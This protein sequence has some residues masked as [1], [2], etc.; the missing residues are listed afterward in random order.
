MCD[1]SGPT[2]ESKGADGKETAAPNGLS[3]AWISLP[4][5]VR[6]IGEK[7]AAKPVTST[8]SMKVP[9]Y[10][11]P[12]RYGFGRQPALFAYA[13]AAV[14][15]GGA[16]VATLGLGSAVKN[17]PT[18]FFCSVVLSSWFG[19]VG[20]GIFAGLL[21]AIALDYY[22]I[23]PI[24]A[25]G[26][27]IEEAPDMIAFVA[28]AFFVSWLSGE[29]KRA[30]HSPR[31]ARN[32]LDAKVCE[33]ASKL[34]Q[35]EDQLQIG[36]A[37]RRT[38]EK[39]ITGEPT[40]PITD[41]PRKRIAQTEELVRD[42]CSQTPAAEKIE[43]G[44][45]YGAGESVAHVPTLHP[46]QES[47]LLR[48][49]DYWTVQYQGQ[50]ARF[51][52]TRGLQYLASL[53]GHP[54][55]EFHVSELIASV[56][57]GPAAFGAGSASG[58]ST[59]DENQMRSVRFQDAGPILDARAKAEYA[60]RLA[61][62]REALDD[63]ERLNDLELASRVQQERDCIAD[64][65]ARAVG[66]GGRNRKAASHAERARSAVTKSIKNSIHKVAEAMPALGRHLGNRIKTGYFCSYNPHPD[67]P[68]WW[69]LES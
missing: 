38:A 57:E 52:A 30:R 22:F 59:E 24:Y 29:Q 44:L 60:C 35:T 17:I 19:G 55:R 16:V 51:K 66:L 65:L 39:R 45:L 7:F 13:V 32:K 10:T 43:A 21:S 18:L 63:A 64:Q 28:S 46:V 11:S 54:G 14:A 3:L 12:D 34:G 25:L 42:F 36:T 23:P 69:E 47:V 48:Q 40:T 62:L 5:G 1:I 37:P 4:K 9:I 50:I 2:R 15:V 26:I 41:E 6:G 58:T 67:R 33:K 27:S 20:P 49:G 8:A 61:E 31:E 56:T 68:V 53:L